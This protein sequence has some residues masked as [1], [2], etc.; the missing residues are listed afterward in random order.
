MRDHICFYEKT[1]TLGKTRPQKEM[2]KV[3]IDFRRV[4]CI[5]STAYMIHIVASDHK[6]KAIEVHT[7]LIIVPAASELV[8]VEAVDIAGNRVD[9][10]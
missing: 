9:R 7:M 3:I 10:L 4:L 5:A 6:T 8:E 1:L 2:R